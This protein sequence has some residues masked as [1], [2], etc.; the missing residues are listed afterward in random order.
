MLTNW[1]LNKNLKKNK[2]NAVRKGKSGTQ[3]QEK[4][5]SEF[6]SS[7]GE[8]GHLNGHLNLEALKYICLQVSITSD[9]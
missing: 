7:S 8:L 9:E 1:N 3:S 4:N 2:V 6:P 5:L